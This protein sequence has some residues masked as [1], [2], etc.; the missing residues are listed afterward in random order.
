MELTTLFSNANFWLALLTIIVTN[1]LLSGDNAVMIALA[2]RHLPAELQKK[3]VLWGSAA[4]VILLV[5]L[6]I[7]AVEL[8]T[9]IGR[10]HV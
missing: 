10:A 3:A 1:L 5:V 7:T 8:L 4:A 2:A 6:T 9:Q